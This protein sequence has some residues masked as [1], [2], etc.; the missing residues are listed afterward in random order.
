MITTKNIPIY[1]KEKNSPSVRCQCFL[2]SYTS[3]SLQLSWVVRV[4]LRVGEWV[5]VGV[6]LF[7]FFIIIISVLRGRKDAAEVEKKGKEK[8]KKKCNNPRNF[9]SN[10]VEEGVGVKTGQNK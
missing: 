7:L 9:S 10:R 5:C 2:S 8:R 4:F 1:T 6:L 3:L